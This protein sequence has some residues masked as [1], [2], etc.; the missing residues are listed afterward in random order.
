MSLNTSTWTANSP[1]TGG[2]NLG[3]PSDRRYGIVVSTGSLKDGIQRNIQVV[4]VG[5]E[6]TSN[7]DSQKND[8]EKQQ[9]AQ[10]EARSPLI[11]LYPSYVLEPAR[12]SD[13]FNLGCQFNIQI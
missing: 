11:S 7:S 3:T 13:A 2:K 6:V 4:A 1:S 9:D 8:Q 12:A 5:S 10:E